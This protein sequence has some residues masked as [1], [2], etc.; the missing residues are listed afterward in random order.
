MRGW[1]L[2]LALLLVAPAGAGTLTK[3]TL[4]VLSTS[5]AVGKVTPCGCHTPKGGFATPSP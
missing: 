5:D 3:K 2:V 4:P 1:S